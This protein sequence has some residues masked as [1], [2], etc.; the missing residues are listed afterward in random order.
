MPPLYAAADADE[1]PAAAALRRR[2]A[3]AMSQPL[4]FAIYAIDAALSPDASRC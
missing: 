3:A 1:M 4:F 2:Y